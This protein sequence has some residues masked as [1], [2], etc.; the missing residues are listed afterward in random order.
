MQGEGRK[1][2]LS[3]AVYVM[4][5]SV[6][7]LARTSAYIKNITLSGPITID[8]INDPKK[9]TIPADN[10][11]ITISRVIAMSLIIVITV[12]LRRD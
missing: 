8:T 6:S 4:S 11:D 7:R 5:S 2:V 1:A 3:P 9:I 12:V 10:R